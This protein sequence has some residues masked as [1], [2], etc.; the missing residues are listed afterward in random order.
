MSSLLEN[1]T[2]IL[3]EKPKNKPVIGCQWVY[4][5]KTDSDGAVTRCK[6]RLVVN[7][8]SQKEGID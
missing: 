5:Y 1:N 3:V 8:C 4:R 7:G 2:W 6:A